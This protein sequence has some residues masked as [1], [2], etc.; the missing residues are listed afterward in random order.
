MLRNTADD[1]GLIAILLHWLLAVTIV[2][3]FSFGL[4]MTG[5][6]YYDP[7]YRRAPELHKSIGVLL[8]VAMGLRLA[9]RVGNPVPRA[10]PGHSPAQRRLAAVSHRLL[11]LL[12]F[13]VMIAGYLIS[14]ADGRPITVFGLFKI[15]AT[16]SGL[17]NQEDIAGAVHELL[18]FA[19]IG[20][21]ALHA[22]AALKHHFIDRDRT[23]QR[24]VGRKR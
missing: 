9:W 5:L 7:W 2:A 8:F 20:L 12:P 15:P 19:L 10:L 13:A 3:L 17:D 4:W 23:L 21:A 18:A 22:L 16:L 11:Y 24:I 1:Y 6:D 14:T